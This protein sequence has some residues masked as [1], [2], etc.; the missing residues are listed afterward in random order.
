MN[1]FEIFL[2]KEKVGEIYGNMNQLKLAIM[3]K[4]RELKV[5]PMKLVARRAAAT[6]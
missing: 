6:N 5:A 2:G 1:K 4:A 3:K